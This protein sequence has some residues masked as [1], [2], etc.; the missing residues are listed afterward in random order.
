MEAAQAELQGE[1]LPRH[2][3]EVIRYRVWFPARYPVWTTLAGSFVVL[4]TSATWFY[5]GAIFWSMLVGLGLTLSFALLLFPTEVALDG[6]ALHQRHLW[7]PRT[8]MLGDF[9]RLTVSEGPLRRI[10]LHARSSRDP[11]AHVNQVVIP[12]PHAPY[13]AEAIIAHIQRRLNTKDAATIPQPPSA[14]VEEHL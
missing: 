6:A 10:V 11:R 12:L 13:A 7:H 4:C 8:W 2:A 3:G 1:V 5:T 9:N 14:G